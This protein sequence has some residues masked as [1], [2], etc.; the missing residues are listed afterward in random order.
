MLWIAEW[1]FSQCLS[2]AKTQNILLNGFSQVCLWIQGK[3]IRP[4]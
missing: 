3:K 4:E 1:V 2:N